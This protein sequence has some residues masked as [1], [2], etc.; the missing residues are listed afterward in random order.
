MLERGGDSIKTDEYFE[1]R[2]LHVEQNTKNLSDKFLKD[3]EKEYKK[4]YKEIDTELKKY[5]ERYLN[6]TDG[7]AV[8]LKQPLSGAELAK[9]CGSINKTIETAGLNEELSRSLQKR[10]LQGQYS[11]LKALQNQI[12]LQLEILRRSTDLQTFEHLKEAYEESYHETTD[13][14]IQAEAIANKKIFVE[15]SNAALTINAIE[16]VVK[17]P[18][19][20]KSFSQRIW[21]NNKKAI[22]EV[23]STLATGLMQGH[24]V[25]K[26]SRKLSKNMETS[27][28]DAKRLVRTET[29]YVLNQATAD[30]YANAGIEQYKFVATLD[31]ITSEVCRSLDLKIFD[32]TKKQ[33]G[34]N[35]PPMHP[36]CRSTTI[37]Y[38]PEYA[39]EDPGSRIAKGVDGK[40]YYIPANTSYTEWTDS[41]S[42]AERE[43]FE[44]QGKIH[45]NKSSDK[46]QYDRYKGM[47]GKDIPNSLDKFQALKYNDS[48]HYKLMKIDYARRNRLVNNPKLKLPNVEKAVISEDKFTKYLFSGIHE[49][50]LNKGRLITKRLGYDINNYKELEVDILKRATLNPA[51]LKSEDKFGFK[52]EQKIIF[53]SKNET[54]T[55]VIVG[56][57]V[58]DDK[59]HMSSIYIKE[60]KE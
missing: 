27:F 33:V 32:V 21:K 26:M 42:T 24:S 60:A 39:D 35:Y 41:M 16:K 4:A 50:G 48:E 3:L 15:F 34:I 38:F 58:K 56:W 18:W 11:R 40:Y 37:P 8:D 29:N 30:S 6:E 13:T 19:S 43:V 1:K 57:Q 14:L 31:S 5:H 10:Y 49:A 28:Y 47:L 17:N 53:Y 22:R 9:Y 55:N 52:Y 7:T 25:D 23:K 36:N 20:Q 45:K 54:P 46:N 2:A 12:E 59:T 44:K 51:T